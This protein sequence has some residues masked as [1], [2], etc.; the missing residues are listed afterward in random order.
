[1]APALAATFALVSVGLSLYVFDLR[2]EVDELSAPTFNLPSAEIRLGQYRT[3]GTTPIAFPSDTKR[4]RL[5]FVVHADI[6][7]RAR[8]LEI[9]TWG[10][11]IVNRFPLDGLKAPGEVH[12]DL[13]RRQ[14]PD[15]KYRVKVYPAAG[16]SAPELYE[17]TLVVRTGNPNPP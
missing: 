11:A 12:L 3:G 15:G 10:G 7:D 16:F 5:V 1:M 4:L 2:R 17:E 13:F 14:L 8:Y 9:S 6:L